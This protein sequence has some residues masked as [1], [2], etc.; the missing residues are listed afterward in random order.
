[1]NLFIMYNTTTPSVLLMI[2]KAWKTEYVEQNNN[3]LI[4][5]H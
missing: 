4:T 2:L 5:I 1:M 3:N